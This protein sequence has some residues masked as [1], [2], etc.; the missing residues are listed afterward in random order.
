MHRKYNFEKNQN[1]YCKIRWALTSILV[2]LLEYVNKSIKVNLEMWGEN[3]MTASI[4]SQVSE[5]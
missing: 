1:S 5:Y 2:Y 3:G 4:E